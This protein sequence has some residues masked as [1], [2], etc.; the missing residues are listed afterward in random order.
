MFQLKRATLI[1][2]LAFTLVALSVV[3]VTIAWA[4]GPPLLTPVL[5]AALAEYANIPLPAHFNTPQLNNIDNTPP[6]NPVTKTT[7]E[8]S[9]LLR[10]Q[11]PRCPRQR[12]G[13]GIYQALVALRDL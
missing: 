6:N 8:N 7:D 9:A 11:G 4:Q 5:P 1:K 2:S 13:G 12:D 3:G 10:R